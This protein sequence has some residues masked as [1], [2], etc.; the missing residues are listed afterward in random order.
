MK[1]SV[2]LFVVLFLTTHVILVSGQSSSPVNQTEHL[3]T[4]DDLRGVKTRP[5]GAAT[6][7][8]FINNTSKPVK[9][10]WI[11]QNGKRDSRPGAGEKLEP[12]KVT[13]M[14][15][16]DGAAFVVT[17]EQD[18]AI[19]VH[20]AEKKS[21]RV[22]IGGPLVNF[23]TPARKYDLITQGPWT[24]SV[25]SSLYNTNRKLASQAADLLS[26]NLN[27]VLHLLPS[28]SHPVVKSLKLFIMHGTKHKDREQGLQ[29][30]HAGEPAFI[31][32]L[33]QNWNHALVVYSAENYVYIN[34]AS[35]IWGLKSTLHEVAHGYHRSHWP[36]DQPDMVNA[37]K[38]AAEKG[39]YRNVADVEKK[40]FIHPVAYAME[41]NSEYF[42]ELTACY[43]FR[44]NY[45]PDTR[46]K[47]K[48]YDPMGYALIQKLWRVSDQ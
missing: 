7:I 34:A 40:D 18:H 48:T 31:R 27:K 23:R 28:H 11:D 43:F 15:T 4:T 19:E 5:E 8:S 25:E 17:D 33:D 46:S 9:I 10:Y 22:E 41:N 38:N 44:I 6:E 42:A 29:Y 45:Y 2:S 47:L 13:G 36:S 37:W 39:L 20:Y 21:Y 1:C 3:L 26:I 30:F 16:S 24:I 12:G 35:E 32:S 14:T